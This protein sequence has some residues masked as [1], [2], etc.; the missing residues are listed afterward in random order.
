MDSLFWEIVVIVL[1]VSANGLFAMAEMALVS[2]RR[3]RLQQQAEEG[4]PG[5]TAA[6]D[7]ANAPNQFLST[8]QIGITLIGVLAGAFGGA[9]L[10]ARLEGWF[11]LIPWLGE[12]AAVAGFGVVVVGITFLSLIVGEL[13]PKR[14]AL[15]Y[16]EAISI[17]MAPAMRLL[18]RIGAPVVYL[19]GLSTDLVLRAFGFKPPAESPVTED[20]VKRM[21]EEGTQ[22]GVFEPS[23]Q[24]MVERV[25]RL[26]DRNASVLMTPRPEVVWLDPD[27]PAEEIHRKL[28]A[29]NHTHYPVAEGQID[30]VI[31]L[32]NA[33]DLLSQNL[34]C[35][36][37]DL[38]SVLRPALF[39]PES[40]PALDVLERFKKK[41]SRVA[42]V[43]D[44]HGGFQGLVTTSDILEAIVGDIPMPDEA[45]EADVIRREDGSWLID[46]K[47]L[48]DELKEVLEVDELPFEDERLYETLGGLVMA[49][50]GRIPTSGERF[51]WGGFRFEVVDMD[52]HRVDK[53]LVRRID[54]AAAA[55]PPA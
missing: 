15:S 9:T 39:V 19:L 40:M 13:V 5:A 48:A 10:G 55:A 51:D 4:N 12:H 47:L 21:I 53:V 1:L 44:E 54:P 16:A 7:L 14:I 42:I 36:P 49:A 25:F 8:I 29:T 35:R 41:R 3:A 30:R 23:E 22:V 34:S 46:G 18:S 17:R 33:K 52:G 2:S 28:T 38:R 31:G 6:L 32:V 43:I 11:K 20:E 50:L 26:G 37:I 45:E 24:E 27:E